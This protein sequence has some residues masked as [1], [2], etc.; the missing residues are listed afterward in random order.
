MIFFGLWVCGVFYFT[1]THDFHRRAC[2]FD[3][4]QKKSFGYFMEADSCSIF[5]GCVRVTCH[6][7]QYACPMYTVF[8]GSLDYQAHGSVYIAVHL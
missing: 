1:L 5:K 3:F 8:S 6:V 4:T 2:G 7:V